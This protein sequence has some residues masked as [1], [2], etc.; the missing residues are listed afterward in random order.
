[1]ER[2]DNT[3]D[4][5]TFV[6]FRRCLR[7]HGHSETLFR[8]TLDLLKQRGVILEEGTCVDAVHHAGSYPACYNIDNMRIR[9][10]YLV[11]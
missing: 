1:M 4:E 2:K 3:P 6:I 9:K 10:A 11:R 7:K 8:K 5:T